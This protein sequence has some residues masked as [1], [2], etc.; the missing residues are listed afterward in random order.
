M[1]PANTFM[2]GAI[3]PD[4][5]RPPALSSAFTWV[6]GVFGIEAPADMATDAMNTLNSANGQLT[7]TLTTI[8]T[9]VNQAQGYSSSSDQTVLG[10]AQACLAEGAGLV[11]NY[12][13]LQGASGSLQTQI[14]TAQADP[15]LTKDTAQSLKDAA[16]TYATQVST[17]MS[18][19]NQLT[20]DVSALSGAAQSGPGVTGF[21]ENLVSS[22]TSKLTYLIGGG[23]LI[24]F[25]APTFI[26]RLARGIKKAA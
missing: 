8:Q 1:L 7:G 14:T 24:Y 26:P 17:F 4:W 18:G 19:I 20:K 12:Q 16:S 25:L 6:E 11:S 3:P 10:K 13:T 22:S 21:V 15:N 5:Q 23:L 9:L 2:Q